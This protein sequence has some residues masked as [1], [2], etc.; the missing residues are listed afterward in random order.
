MW[1]AGNK[2]NEYK[3]MLMKTLQ[4][5][6]SLSGHK[7]SRGD[8]DGSISKL[9]GP[10]KRALLGDLPKINFKSSSGNSSSGKKKRSIVSE[11]LDSTNRAESFSGSSSAANRARS[12]LNLA[13]QLRSESGNEERASLGDVPDSLSRLV[14]NIARVRNGNNSMNRRS[15]DEENDD[16]R[17]LIGDGS[18]GEPS[19]KVEESSKKVLQSCEKLYQQMRDVEKDNFEFRRRVIAWKRLNHDAL[20]NHGREAHLTNCI[21]DVS[22]CSSCSPTILKHLLALVHVLFRVR[23]ATLLDTPLN[24]DF[25]SLLFDEGNDNFN[26]DLNRLKRDMIVALATKSALG[27]DM[28]F[29]ELQMRLQGSRNVACAD[30]LG[31]LLAEKDVRSPDKFVELAMQTLK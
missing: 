23:N 22:F 6:K 25:I 4:N 26:T 1:V 5:S 12:L 21:Y 17:D 13:I 10:L 16:K 31:E 19:A 30:I 29:E 27:S 14:A 20:A 3:G 9:N 15:R 7:R 8:T 28:V 18:D 24:K 2:Y 11:N